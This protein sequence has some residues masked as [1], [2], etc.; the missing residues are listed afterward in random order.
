MRPDHYLPLCRPLLAHALRGPTRGDRGA[1]E[2]ALNR[3]PRETF[4]DAGGECG[5]RRVGRGGATGGQGSRVASECSGAPAGQAQPAA[6]AR[7][8]KPEP[9]LPTQ[10]Q[11]EGAGNPQKPLRVKDTGV[12]RGSAPSP[13]DLS[14]WGSR[15]SRGTR[16][17]SRGC[18]GMW[19][20]SFKDPNASLGFLCSL[21]H[22]GP[23]G[24]PVGSETAGRG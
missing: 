24:S 5:S 11:E 23:R 1:G 19:R 22:P 14:R 20:V 10:Q 15:R 8:E 21:G 4:R 17:D 16:P 2:Q 13:A 3:G 12:G 18:Q 9:F 7:L 6:A